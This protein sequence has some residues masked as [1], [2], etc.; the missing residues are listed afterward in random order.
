M[1]KIFTVLLAIFIFRASVQAADK[2]R[3]G[4]PPDAGHF[5][6]PL[7]Q[8]KGFLTGEGFEADII[9]ITGPVANIALA[10]KRRH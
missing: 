8:K 5:T 10:S 2:I 3:I 4:V 9:S 6:F 7:A 1:A